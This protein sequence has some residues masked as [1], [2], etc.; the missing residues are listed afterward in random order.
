[1]EAI[2]RLL[3]RPQPVIVRVVVTALI[4]LVAFGMRLSM[5]DGTGRY[6]FIHFILPIVAAS[7]LFDR[8]A[9]FF[10][11]GVSVA[12]IAS[13]LNWHANVAAHVSAITVFCIV[14]VCLVFVAEGLRTA[15]TKAHAAQEAAGLLLQEMSH[16]VKNKFAMIVSIIGLQARNASPEVKRALEDVA[17]RVNVMATVHNYLQLSRH[18]GLIDMSEYLPSLCDALRD[19]LRG[20]RPITLSVRA[21]PEQF[22]AD[23]AL[24]TGLIVNELVTNAFKYGF[25]ADL[26]GKILV[27]LSHSGSGLE[28]VVTDNG[29]GLS[30]DR[31]AGLG[32][33]LVTVLAAQLGGTAE[34]SVVQDGGCSARVQF[35]P[36]TSSSAHKT[37]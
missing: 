33:R 28:L 37:R 16:R 35:P 8:G 22:P 4:V 14:G 23:K 1:M 3:P 6:G 10:A 15:L 11:I 29:R 25:D 26:P 13:I 31:Q 7:L 34:W 21:I 24:T 5:G 12:L 20:P 17:A 36:T 27:E 18:D 9:G 19:A 32:T 2:F 30:P